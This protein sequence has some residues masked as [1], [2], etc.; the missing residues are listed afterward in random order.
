V[1]GGE[2]AVGAADEEDEVFCHPL[3]REE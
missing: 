3:L 2:N 1:A